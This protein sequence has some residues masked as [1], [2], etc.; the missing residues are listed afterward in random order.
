MPE[1]QLRAHHVRAGGLVETSLAVSEVALDEVLQLTVQEP[2]AEFSNLA[3][4][5]QFRVWGLGVLGFGCFGV[6]VFGCGI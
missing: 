2:G 1:K 4:F 5:R 6:W 3:L